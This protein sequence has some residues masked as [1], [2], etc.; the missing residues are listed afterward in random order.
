M[1]AHKYITG[2]MNL[3]RNT[4]FPESQIEARDWISDRFELLTEDEKKEL[5]EWNHAEELAM[6]EAHNNEFREVDNDTGD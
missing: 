4:S 6:R 2:V 3:L 1:E 5:A